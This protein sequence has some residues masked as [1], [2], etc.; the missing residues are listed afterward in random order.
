M[1]YLLYRQHPTKLGE[2]HLDTTR[3]TSNADVSRAARRYAKVTVLDAWVRILPDEP[4]DTDIPLKVII[5]GGGDTV[6]LGS[7]G[8]QVRE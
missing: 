5:H 4:D 1:R 3:Y 8:A 2:Y 6:Y 7:I